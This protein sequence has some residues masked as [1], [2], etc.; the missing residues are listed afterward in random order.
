VA[1]RE[2]VLPLEKAAHRQDALADGV[3]EEA[4]QLARILSKLRLGDERA[5]PLAANDQVALHEPVHSRTDRHPAH[6][7]LLREL[8]FG[9]EPVAGGEFAGLDAIG[10]LLLDLEVGRHAPAEGHGARRPVIEVVTR[11]LRG[12]HSTPQWT[13]QPIL[14]RTRAGREYTGSNR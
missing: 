3:L 13:G 1:C 14:D 2:Q 6:A 4:A 9:W 10:Q 7:E 5:A 8:A 11:G 12:L